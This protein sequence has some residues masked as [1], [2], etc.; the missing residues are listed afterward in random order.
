[1]S[2]LQASW[3]VVKS[4]WMNIM[5]HGLSKWKKM[6]DFIPGIHDRL[7]EYLMVKYPGAGVE[8]DASFG[9][10]KSDGVSTK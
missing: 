2:E 1:M 7:Y 10:E 5:R 4:P 8:A 6:N 3:T 9:L